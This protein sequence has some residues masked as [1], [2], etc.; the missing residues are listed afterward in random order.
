MKIK[1]NCVHE[2]Q[3]KINGNGTRVANIVDK[4]A[5]PVGKA[6]VRCTVCNN[7]TIVKV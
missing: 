6:A 5:A 7:V 1:C 3:D 2:N 4:V